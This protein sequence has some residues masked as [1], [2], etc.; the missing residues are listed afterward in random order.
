MNN[1]VPNTRT[2]N[3]YINHID[4]SMY[5]LSMS[6][7]NTTR[8][9][10]NRRSS[11]GAGDVLPLGCTECGGTWGLHLPRHTQTCKYTT[12]YRTRATHMSTQ[13][14]THAQ[15]YHWPWHGWEGQVRDTISACLR[16]SVA[17]EGEWTA[18]AAAAAAAGKKCCL[19]I[20]ITYILY[21]Y[22]F[23]T[24]LHH[25]YISYP[26]STALHYYGTSLS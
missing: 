4:L 24:V 20:S 11:T 7:N 26:F 17:N 13:T 10:T 8:V 1:F 15:E 5:S 21:H 2:V 18:A 23:S 9:L 16:A 6:V 19:G 14:R 3:M 22:H 12:H 25:Y